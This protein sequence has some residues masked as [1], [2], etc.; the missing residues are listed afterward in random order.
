MSTLHINDFVDWMIETL[1]DGRVIVRVELGE[2]GSSPPMEVKVWV[3]SLTSAEFVGSGNRKVGQVFFYRMNGR[4]LPP[5]V[6]ISNA[7]N[8]PD[9]CF[10]Y[11]KAL[12]SSFMVP[13][14]ARCHIGAPQHRNV[15]IWHS[16]AIQELDRLLGALLMIARNGRPHEGAFC[17]LLAVRLE[18]CIAEARKEGAVRRSSCNT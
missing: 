9:S 10:R 11:V 3:W 2:T 4:Y 13:E 16:A 5:E 7:S 15:A 1:R 17:E 14:E 12:P 8:W 18:A 6:D